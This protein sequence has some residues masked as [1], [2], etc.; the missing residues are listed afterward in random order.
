VGWA[1]PLQVRVGYIALSDTSGPSVPGIGAK[2]VLISGTL[3]AHGGSCAAAAVNCTGGSG[4]VIQL[5]TADGNI[6]VSGDLLVQGTDGKAA[7]GGSGGSIAVQAGAGGSNYILPNSGTDFRF[8]GDILVHG[9]NGQQAGSGGS[10]NIQTSAFQEVLFFGYSGVD[11]S[12]GDGETDGGD[13]GALVAV[14]GF[15]QS[16]VAAMASYVPWTVSGGD[17][18][19]GSGGEGGHG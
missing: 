17:G 16:H 13:A 14:N 6:H 12:G 18:E 4:G 11:I 1:R 8:S 3:T 19:T 9:G 5:F 15:S 10:V 2:P 7:N